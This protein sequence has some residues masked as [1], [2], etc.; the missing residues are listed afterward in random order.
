MRRDDV[1]AAAVGA[2]ILAH[3]TECS[4]PDEKMRKAIGAALLE[5]ELADL[6]Q[7]RN[8]IRGEWTRRTLRAMHDDFFRT[9]EF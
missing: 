8:Y 3:N 9:T 2:A 5:I 1:L 6:G 4:T 7:C